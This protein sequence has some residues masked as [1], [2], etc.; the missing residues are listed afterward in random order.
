MTISK[1]NLAILLCA[2]SQQLSAASF[3][4]TTHPAAVSSSSRSMLTPKISDGTGLVN[5]RGNMGQ[6]AAA[7]LLD[8]QSTANKHSAAHG[9]RARTT[10]KRRRGEIPL[11]FQRSN[12]SDDLQDDSST[13]SSTEQEGTLPLPRLASFAATYPLH[14]ATRFLR[15]LHV[16]D[17]GLASFSKEI[18]GN[19]VLSFL[20]SLCFPKLHFSPVILT[21]AITLMKRQTMLTRTHSW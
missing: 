1:Q 12:A 8:G 10:Y 11:A 19:S 21:I 4:Q 15:T 16:S 9:N 18:V 17:N 7:Y 13:R 14:D 5:S 2:A 20:A 3:V 6:S